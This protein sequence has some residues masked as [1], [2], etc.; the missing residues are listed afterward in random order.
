ML[1]S[2][3]GFEEC[4][5]APTRATGQAAGIGYPDRPVKV[6]QA[7]NPLVRAQRIDYQ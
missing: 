4:W 3:V 7:T 2:V 5:R 6:G 1:G